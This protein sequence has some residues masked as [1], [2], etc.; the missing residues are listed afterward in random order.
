MAGNVRV[1]LKS[2]FDDKGIKNAERQLQSISSGI[3]TAFKGIGVAALATTAAVA[4]FSMDSIKSASNLAESTNAVNVAFGEA[5]ES[6][7]KIGESSAESLGLAR[8]EFNGAAVRF[9]AFAERVVGESGNIAGFIGDVTTRAADFASVF[10]IEVSEALRVF[11]SGLAGEAEPLKRFGINLLE[12]EVKAYALRAGIIDVGESM[13]ETQKVQARYGL[14][15]ESTNKTAGDFANTSDSLANRQRILKASFEDIMAE[16]GTA[17]LPAFEDLVGVVQEDLLP[18]FKD[19]AEK[20]GPAVADILEFIAGVFE[21]AFTEGTDLN[22]ALGELE[23]SFDLLFGVISGGT[24]DAEGFSDTLSNLI[25]VIEWLI[26]TAAS[27]T[28]GF[29]GFGYA[30]DALGRGDIGEFWKFLTTDTIDY[31]NAQRL[32]TDEMTQVG[33]QTVVAGGHIADLNNISL[34]GLR[35]EIDSVTDRVAANAGWSLSGLPDYLRSSILGTGGGTSTTTATPTT[36][37]SSGP[38][39]TERQRDLLENVNEQIDNALS[40]YNKTV[41]RAREAYADQIANLEERYADSIASATTARD[42]GLAQAALDHASNIS[43]IQKDFADKQAAIIQKSIDRL[44]DAYRS[45]VETNVVDL[46]GTEQVGKSVDSLVTS[47]RDK[48]NAS[49]T[50]LE[51]SAQLASQG[52]SQTFIEQVVGAGTETGNELASAI[53]EATPETQAELQDLF[54]ALEVESTSGMD[55]LAQTM[56]EKTGLATD[57]LKALYTQTN[58]DLVAALAQA[59]QDYADTQQN[60]LDTFQEAMQ[61]AMDTR[62]DAFAT[63]NE[64]LNDALADAAT[65]LNEQLESIQKDFEKRIDDMGG[66]VASL[67]SEIDALYARLSSPLRVGTPTVTAPTIPSTQTVPT[68]KSQPTT[69]INLD[70]KTDQTQSTAQVGAVIAKTINKYANT[71]GVVI[72]GTGSRYIV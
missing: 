42:E 68:T 44:R 1:V 5:A 55:T 12:S 59:E 46:F 51:N 34:A 14:L 33:S 52:F 16:V 63:A 38:S 8:T 32:A 24:K 70:V 72:G 9:S 28:A 6:V 26:T 54:R 21:Q 40:G 30:M 10:N 43:K 36:T 64:Q 17:M 35:S 20:V 61:D 39:R 49:R 47:L 60:I 2:V 58:E 53:L 19:I 27:L 71:G 62:K 18:V 66:A 31:V 65:A 45:A 56:Y 13:D 7:L 4:K 57:E 3:T 22:T 37:R 29:E 48:L 41:A 11:Q 69:V 67:R 50:L 15:M 25:Y 23:E